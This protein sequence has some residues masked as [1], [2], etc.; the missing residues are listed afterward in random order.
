MYIGEK[1]KVIKE[2][3]PYSG[4]SVIIENVHFRYNPILYSCLTVN[5]V[6]VAF[7]ETELQS[8]YEHDM[9]M[10]KEKH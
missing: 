2:N 3:C 6:L 10:L 4:Q 1:V 8:L 9:K 7:Y 5:G